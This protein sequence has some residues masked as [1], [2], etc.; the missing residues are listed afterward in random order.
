[1]DG[2]CHGGM[3][4]LRV[5]SVKHRVVGGQIECLLECVVLYHVN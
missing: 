5:I 1:M 2:E 4:F 3:V